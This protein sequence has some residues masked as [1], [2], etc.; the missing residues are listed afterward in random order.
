[1]VLITDGAAKNSSA[2]VIAEPMT[3][4]AKAAPKTL[5]R[6]AAAID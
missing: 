1:L 4:P 2:A 5:F 3:A 6:G